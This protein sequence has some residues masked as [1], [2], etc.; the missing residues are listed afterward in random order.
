[1]SFAYLTNKCDDLPSDAVQYTNGVVSEIEPLFGFSVMA[2]LLFSRVTLWKGKKTI[3]IV[4]LWLFWK[5]VHTVY[6]LPNV[7][8]RIL[9]DFNVM[10]IK[11]FRAIFYEMSCIVDNF[12]CLFDKRVSM[13]WISIKT[14][15]N[16]WKINVLSPETD[17][18]AWISWR[19]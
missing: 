4:L 1:M 14:K 6:Y 7:A 9:T 15:N 19:H 5:V 8:F 16:L 2:P 10:I 13:L 11:N 12:E 18:C 17:K 3:A